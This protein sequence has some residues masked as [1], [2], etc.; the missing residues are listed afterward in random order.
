[1][2]ITP[3]EFQPGIYF[4]NIGSAYLTNNR[5]T[6]LTLYDLK[7]YYMNIEEMSKPIEI[8]TQLCETREAIK[9]E[10]GATNNQIQNRFNEIQLKRDYQRTRGQKREKSILN[11]VGNIA[12]DLFGVLD[13]RF[14]EMYTEDL[15]RI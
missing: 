8:L 14:G 5:W 11:I 15:G 12:S 9:Q 1:M 2:Q 4:E 7:N 3:F 6:I 10:C 13:S